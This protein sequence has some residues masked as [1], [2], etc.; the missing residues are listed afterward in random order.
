MAR[1]ELA[2]TGD[3]AEIAELYLASWDDALAGVRR[4][5]SD[6]LVR[7]WIRKVLLNRGTTWLA[8]SDA[9]IVGFMTLTGDELDQLYLLPGYYRRGL[10]RRLVEVAK[11]QC[12][13]RLHLYTFRCNARARVFYEAQG[14]HVTSA[15]DGS[16]NE[17][18]E[19]DMRYEWVATAQA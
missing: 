16:R 2:T 19:P 15:D 1:I 14:F 18:N 7:D 5:H 13:G 6:E 17:E 12:S 11:Q 9:R 4:A 3:A 8:R 10:G